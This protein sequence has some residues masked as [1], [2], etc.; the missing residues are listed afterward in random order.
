[1]GKKS[2]PKR[3]LSL[4]RN[5]E[6][7]NFQQLQNKTILIFTLIN[8]I[9]YANYFETGMFMLY[10]WKKKSIQ[11]LKLVISRLRISGKDTHWNFPTWSLIWSNHPLRSTVWTRQSNEHPQED[12]GNGAKST[13]G[14][15][16]RLR[17]QTLGQAQPRAKHACCLLTWLL[18]HCVASICNFFS[19]C[20]IWVL[21]L[22]EVTAEAIN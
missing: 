16:K 3:I 6:L 11:S 22:I 17:S 18:Y 5:T 1:M 12:G 15:R 9:K 8:L 20:F 19:L 7:Y 2:A 10:F 21:I 4:N 13:A 14:M